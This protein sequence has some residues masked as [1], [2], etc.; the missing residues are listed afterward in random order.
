MTGVKLES[1]LK[2]VDRWFNIVAFVFTL[3]ETVTAIFIHTRQ[4][5]PLEPDRSSEISSQEPNTLEALIDTI[6]VIGKN[7]KSTCILLPF[8]N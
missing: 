6:G 5:L 2:Y 3:L 8:T 7:G 4:P 1:L